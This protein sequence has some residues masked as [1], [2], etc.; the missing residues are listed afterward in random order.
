MQ[1]YHNIKK[2]SAAKNLLP[3][4]DPK[5]EDNCNIILSTELNVIKHFRIYNPTLNQKFQSQSQNQADTGRNEELIDLQKK[6][7]EK[8]KMTSEMKNELQGEKDAHAYSI[9]CMEERWGH[10]LKK[11]N[12]CTEKNKKA[13][14]ESHRKAMWQT[15]TNRHHQKP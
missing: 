12:R 8:D 7:D 5:A 15:K 3:P 2:S 9:R 6:K 1:N 14:R 11:K 10:C 4:N 13:R